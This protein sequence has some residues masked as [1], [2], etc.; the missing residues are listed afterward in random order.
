MHAVNKDIREVRDEE[1][2]AKEVKE[3]NSASI[4]SYEKTQYLK[5]LTNQME[6]N[7]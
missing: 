6:D 3:Q 1:K 2:G 5:I 4:L 7:N